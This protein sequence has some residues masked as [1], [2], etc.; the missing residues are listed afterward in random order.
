MDNLEVAMTSFF[1]SLRGNRHLPGKQAARSG[2]SYQDLELTR[3]QTHLGATRFFAN[4]IRKSR[5]RL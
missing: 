3:F 5:F 1:V 2:Q 4:V